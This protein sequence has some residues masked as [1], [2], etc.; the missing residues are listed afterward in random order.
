M[1]NILRLSI[2]FLSFA[3]VA[4]DGNARVIQISGTHSR[5]EIAAK[6]DAVGGE[7][8]G[9]SAKH[10]GYTC[11]NFDKGTSVACNAKGHC[12]GYVPD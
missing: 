9:T 3:V 8:G 4:T 7:K 2:V 5:G 12:T 11:D 1:K 10:G 6:C